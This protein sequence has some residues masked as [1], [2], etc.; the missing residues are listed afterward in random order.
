MA[1]SNPVLIEAMEETADRLEQG[2]A[3]SW[4]HMGRCNCGHL[5]QT[6]TRLHPGDIHQ[7]ALR[8]Q[9]NWTEQTEHYTPYCPITGNPLDGV[10]DR[11][12]EIGLNTNDI[13]R[14]EYLSD[15]KVLKRLPG[16]FR[17]LR[18]NCR[19]DLVVYLRTWAGTLRQALPAAARPQGA[20][21]QQVERPVP[22]A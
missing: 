18:R 10:I 6:V 4:S 20:P 21:R 16:G 22:V 11:L 8:G 14:L 17:H 2:A 3:Y 12:V 13:R 1:I 5:A 19:E 9:G 7:R 15:P